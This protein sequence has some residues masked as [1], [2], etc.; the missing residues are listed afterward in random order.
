[1]AEVESEDEDLQDLMTSGPA[2]GRG[3]N[4]AMGEGELEG[5]QPW[6]AEEESNG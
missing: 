2:P 4:G 6:T 3:G 5:F 1:V